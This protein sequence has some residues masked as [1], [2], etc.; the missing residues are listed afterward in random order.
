VGRVKQHA[1]SVKVSGEVLTA[2]SWL[3]S[4]LASLM[5]VVIAD[6]VVVTKLRKL[7]YSWV[8]LVIRPPIC[9][10]NG[11]QLVQYASTLMAR[12]HQVFLSPQYYREVTI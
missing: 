10:G 1:D 12:L 11:H 4:S 7:V 9:T 5:R 6:G 8:K 2:L 3:L